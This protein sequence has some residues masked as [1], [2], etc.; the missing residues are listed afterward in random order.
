MTDEELKQYE[1]V[2]A[3]KE[4]EVNARMFFGDLLGAIS[5]YPGMAEK[6]ECKEHAMAEL[7]KMVAESRVDAV[8]AIGEGPLAFGFLVRI[9]KNS[10]LCFFA[11]GNV[12]Q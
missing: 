2:L 1:L 8:R 11:Y 4:M 7:E 10:F 9:E 5:F 3:D 12:D 6:R